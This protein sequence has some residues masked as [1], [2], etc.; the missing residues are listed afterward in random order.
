MVDLR[1]IRALV[2]EILG[3]AILAYAGGWSYLYT[4]KLKG[5]MNPRTGFKQPTFLSAATSS[6][7]I[8]LFAF[9][10]TGI[11]KVM[12][13]PMATLALMLT[14]Q[15]RFFVGILFIAG[16]FVGAFAG[17]ALLEWVI[18]SS[19]IHDRLDYNF[20][21]PSVLI[22]DRKGEKKFM[23]T[24]TVEGMATLFLV[25][26]V[27]FAHVQWPK[28]SFVRVLAVALG[29]FIGMASIQNVSGG[30]LG[31]L[32]VFP[33]CLLTKNWFNGWWVYL[34]G[35]FV[36]MLLAIILCSFFVGKNLFGVAITSAAVGEDSST[37]DICAD[38]EN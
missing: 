32:R 30:S 23:S 10:G 16:Q 19:S 3:S 13:N 15:I 4:N 6:S 5:A 20:T 22:Q 7:I 31:P 17:A 1:V 2:L 35:P 28:E 29:H 38:E 34:V 36:G 11:E 24:I 37:A 9:A 14:K 12:L 21:Y 33:S 18:N 27:L 26:F 25:I 8:G